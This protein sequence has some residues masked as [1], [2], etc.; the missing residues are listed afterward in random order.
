[1]TGNWYLSY[2][3]SFAHTYGWSDGIHPS[4]WGKDYTIRLP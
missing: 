3:R 2:T 1:M 4:W